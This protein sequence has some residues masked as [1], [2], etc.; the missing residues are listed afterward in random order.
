MGSVIRTL[1]ILLIAVGSLSAQSADLRLFWEPELPRDQS[2]LTLWRSIKAFALSRYH[3]VQDGERY[4]ATELTVELTHGVVHFFH[5]SPSPGRS[6]PLSLKE[7]ADGKF[8][9]NNSLE[10]LIPGREPPPALT[11]RDPDPLRHVRFS[12]KTPEDIENLHRELDQ[13]FKTAFP[14]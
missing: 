10:R 9:E 7:I 6:E 1:A 12:M 14:W 2:F 13:K 4:P 5:I 11:V 8:G 3:I